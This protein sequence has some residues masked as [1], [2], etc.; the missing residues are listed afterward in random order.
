RL[1]AT[2]PGNE[3]PGYL[4]SSPLGTISAAEPLCASS[5]RRRRARA[6]L[7]LS[8]EGTSLHSRTIHCPA[9]RGGSI[10]A[11]H[12]DPPLPICAIRNLWPHVVGA[13]RTTVT[14]SPPSLPGALS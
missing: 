13:K 2:W 11:L 6:Q 3:L 5:T 8:P 12:H 10:D 14:P 1:A 7:W 9:K 4:Q